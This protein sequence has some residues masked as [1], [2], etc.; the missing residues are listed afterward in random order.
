MCHKS[1]I[2]H[3]DK[4]VNIE[5]KAEEKKDTILHEFY[6]RDNFTS[7]TDV[8]QVFI[9]DKLIFEPGLYII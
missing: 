6:N 5:E 4:D 7:V 8:L 3:Y 9:N 1:G 2:R